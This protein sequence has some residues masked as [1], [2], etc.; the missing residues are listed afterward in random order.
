MHFFTSSRILLTNNNTFKASEQLIKTL[1][2]NCL[3]FDLSGYN[4]IGFDK[5]LK[6]YLHK[7]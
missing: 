4:R 6:N 1:L 2:N 3:S 7:I 5:S